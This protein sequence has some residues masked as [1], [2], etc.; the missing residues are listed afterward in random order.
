MA[1]RKTGFTVMKRNGLS[2]LRPA[3]GLAFSDWT[4][5]ADKACWTLVED[6]T[7]VRLAGVV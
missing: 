6:G 5:V 4:D 7:R 1:L 3:A 2:W